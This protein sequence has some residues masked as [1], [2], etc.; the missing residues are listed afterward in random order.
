MR[1]I[2]F[3]S[4][5]AFPKVFDPS[6][7]QNIFRNRMYADEISEEEAIKDQDGSYI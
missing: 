4:T 7:S 2:Y 1:Y 6:D 5:V 3:M